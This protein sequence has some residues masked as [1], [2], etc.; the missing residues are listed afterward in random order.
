MRIRLTAEFHTVEANEA[1]ALRALSCL[2]TAVGSLPGC[3][4]CRLTIPPDSSSTF[5]L[6]EEWDSEE[7]L[8]Q[9]VASE[10][11]QALL[12]HFRKVDAYPDSLSKF[13]IPPERLTELLA[14]TVMKSGQVD[15]DVEDFCTPISGSAER[16][17]IAGRSASTRDGA[18]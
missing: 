13:A 17:P 8:G 12:A 3:E 2:T 9:H 11:F 14:L 18:A 6:V 16:I 1:T 10:G 7:S 5:L 15:S 4:V